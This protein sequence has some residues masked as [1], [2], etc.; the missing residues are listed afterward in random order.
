MDIQDFFCKLTVVVR[1]ILGMEGQC[2]IKTLD[3][4][5]DAVAKAVI[6][7]EE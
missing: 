5:K 3:E 1:S 7:L 6:A 4:A 2:E